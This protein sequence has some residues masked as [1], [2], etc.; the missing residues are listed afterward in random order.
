RS[1]VSLDSSNAILVGANRFNRST[2]S[3]ISAWRPGARTLS[4]SGLTMSRPGFAQWPVPTIITTG[5]STLI[6]APSFD[7]RTVLS[8][9][10]H[11]RL[12]ENQGVEGE[13]QVKANE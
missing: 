4:N 7:F 11:H 3:R 6:G 12:V 8:A 2:R 13:A 10:V 1:D 9:C 5:R